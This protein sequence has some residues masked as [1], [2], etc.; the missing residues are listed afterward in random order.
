[1]WAYLFSCDIREEKRYKRE[2]N[3]LSRE[4]KSTRKERLYLERPKRRKPTYQISYVG[5]STFPPY[6]LLRLL[7]DDK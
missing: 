7:L 1:V 6:I 3:V 5:L 4:R 2:G